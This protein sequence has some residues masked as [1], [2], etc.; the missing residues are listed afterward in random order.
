[1]DGKQL[2]QRSISARASEWFLSL[3]NKGAPMSFSQ[4]WELKIRT[5][6]DS[7]VL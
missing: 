1:M 5:W 2:G 7:I 3:C 4:D 6:K